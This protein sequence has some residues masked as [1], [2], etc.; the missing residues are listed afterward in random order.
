MKLTVE[1]AL[2]KGKSH[3]KNGE[4]EEAR[5][6]YAAVLEAF[7]NNS[8]AKLALASL[9]QPFDR[10]ISLY[11]AGRTQD[12]IWEATS[13]LEEFGS[14]SVL[15]NILGAAHKANGQ[16]NDA[17]VAYDRALALKPDGA[18]ICFNMGVALQEQGKLEDAIAAY[19]RALAVKPDFA[20]AYNN[21]GVTL[22]EQGKLEDAIAAYERALSLKPDDADTYNN[23]GVTLQEQGKLED[24]IAAYERALSLKPDDA[25]TYNNMGNAL[26]DQ[27]KREEAIAAYERALY[28]KPDDADASSNKGFM[29][30]GQ[31]KREEAIAAYERAL[32]PKSEPALAYYNMGVLHQEQGKREEAIA[33]YERA[34]ALKPDF[35][36]AHNNIGVLL[37]EQ[38]K[39]EDAIAAY[40][41]ALS[42]KPD[43]ALAEAQMLHQKTH[44]C[45]FS[46]S[47]MLSDASK[48]LGITTGAVPPFAALCWLD[49]SEHQLQRS[50]KWAA[51]KYKQ[52]PLPLPARPTTPLKRLKIGYFSADFHDHATMYLMA[53]L[54]RHHNAE[55]FEV[56]IY[57]YGRVK[58]SFERKKITS[59]VDH[60]FDVAGKSDSQISELAREHSLDIA[61]DLK[62]YTAET[63]SSI[64][65]YRLAP[66]Q[67]NYLGYPGSMGADFIDYIIAD[68]VVIPNNQRQFYSEKVI[69]L[70]HCY[71]P[72]DNT[73]EIDRTYT[74]RSDFSLPENAFVF[75]CFNNNYKISPSEF[76]I[77]MRLLNKVDDSVLWLL[78]ANKWAEQNLKREAEARGV[79][80]GRLVFAEIVTHAEHLGR[81]KHADLF[82]DTFNY[83]AH[84]TTSDALW[85]GLPVVTRQGKQFS[86]RVAA[87]LLASIGLRELITNSEEEYEKLILDLAMRP[88]KLSEIKE[89]L[90]KNRLTEP[91]FDTLRYTQNFEK[92]LQKAYDLFFANEQPAD[93]W[94]T[95]D[96]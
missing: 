59:S 10:L 42:L 12:V 58:S 69:Y 96:A 64:F 53:G 22:Q 81:L 47:A 43:F 82:V 61:I 34:L 87:S 72:N 32:S 6:V 50:K 4:L 9:D 37:Q 38:G 85:G 86:A 36:D 28:L 68:P 56:F 2:L 76:D 67:I 60:F 63:R 40:E 88:Q 45:D 11:S 89:K 84:T 54:L 79:D 27:G 90:A 65:Q 13:L 91:L 29:H 46:I 70:P 49:N 26:K 35:A 7:P 95:D 74:K 16:L 51:E 78:K 77:W 15:W 44:I 21:M 93:I 55:K 39:L 18:D 83:N 19:E 33:A 3:Q 62:G 24:A 8:R 75:C 52:S 48:R 80:Q 20:D 23:M 94:V 71:Q 25:D 14:S 66:I 17:I 73:R 92:G 57:S 30:Q 41:C 1:R 5:A 31:G